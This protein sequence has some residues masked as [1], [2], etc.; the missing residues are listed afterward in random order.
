MV[1]SP[2][3]LRYQLVIA[4]A[5]LRWL[6]QSGYASNLM[7]GTRAQYR[8]DHESRAVHIRIERH[9]NEQVNRP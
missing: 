3:F 8:T 9:A 2:D 1:P 6:Y 5:R 4:I 7:T